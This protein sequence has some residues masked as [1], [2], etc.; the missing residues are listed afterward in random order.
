MNL[1]KVSFLLLVLG[2]GPLQA[3]ANE[4]LMQA[5]VFGS[6]K[7]AKK[8]LKAEKRHMLNQIYSGHEQLNGL[9][10]R[11]DV[12]KTSIIQSSEHAIDYSNKFFN[13]MQQNMTILLESHITWYEVR[14][15]MLTKNYEMAK[16][17]AHLEKTIGKIIS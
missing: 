7:Q 6:E 2:F 12:Y 10:E 9:Q 15:A 8:A 4:D 1:I 14:E 16:M 5:I 13:R 3:D 11:L 17:Y